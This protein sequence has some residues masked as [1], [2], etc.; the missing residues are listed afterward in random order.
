MCVCECVCVC[1]C[2]WGGGGGG[3]MSYFLVVWG[4]GGGGGG[5]GVCRCHTLLMSEGRGAKD[6]KTK[7]SSR[8]MYHTEVC[9]LF[10][11]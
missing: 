1:V 11:F 4:G 2:V 3:R 10:I 5:G 9:K 8:T 7:P 6:Y